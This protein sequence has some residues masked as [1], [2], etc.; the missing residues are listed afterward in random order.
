ME[1]PQQGFGLISMACISQHEWYAALRSS[2]FTRLEALYI[3]TRPSVESARLQ[4]CADHPD[5]DE[6]G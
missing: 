4:W 2:G 5:G 1:V 3:I 6:P